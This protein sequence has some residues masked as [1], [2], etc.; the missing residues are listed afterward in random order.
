[1]NRL[2]FA[3]CTTRII[4]IILLAWIWKS[5]R[6][7]WGHCR[8]SNHAHL[9]LYFIYLFAVDSFDLCFF[10]VAISK[11]KKQNW[12]RILQKKIKFKRK[13]ETEK[14]ELVQKQ[15]ADFGPRFVSIW[16]LTSCIL[17]YLK[18]ESFFVCL[19]S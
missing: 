7:Y 2:A 4:N 5:F 10:I 8:L 11:E 18:R 15:Y 12:F 9:T 1:M 6:I 14:K 19:V 16:S 17:I 3:S 13:N